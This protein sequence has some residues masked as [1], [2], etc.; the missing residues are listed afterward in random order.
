MAMLT[1]RLLKYLVKRKMAQKKPSALLRFSRAKS[2][3]LLFSMSDMG[4][5]QQLL[6]KEFTKRFE[7][8]EAWLFV[9]KKNMDNMPVEGL[10][11]NWHYIELFS[12]D[13]NFLGWPKSKLGKKIPKIEPELIMNFAPTEDLRLT[14]VSSL[15]P[16][17]F[18][19]GLGK[20]NPASYCDLTLSIDSSSSLMDTFEQFCKYLDSLYGHD[21]T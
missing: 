13:F 11:D 8:K 4:L 18:R 19:L 20:A 16:A 5:Y 3:V 6:S 2:I 21:K 15:M 12:K 9:L 10:P 7:G 1:D 17:G 14:Y